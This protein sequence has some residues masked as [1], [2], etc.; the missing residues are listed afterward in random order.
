M[1]VLNLSS[2]SVYYFIHLKK[3]KLKIWSATPAIRLAVT[4]PTRFGPNRVAADMWRI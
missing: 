2:M 3:I 1:V 4:I